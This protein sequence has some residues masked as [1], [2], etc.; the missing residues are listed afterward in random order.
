[1]GVAFHPQYAQNGSFYVNYT[2][3]DGDTVV[4][5]YQVSADPNV[6]DPG[7]GA[8]ILFH[9]DP[10][11]NHNGGNLV[12]GP[13]GYLWIG[14]GDGGAG[15]DPLGSGQNGTSLL[16]KML[17]IDVNGAF[18]YAIPPDNPF[19]GNPNVLPEIWA[20]GLRNP[21]RY[22]F[23]RQT[24]D[25]WIGDV[26]QNSWEEVNFIPAG[27]GG[28][29][30]FGWNVAEGNHCFRSASCDLTPFVAPVAEY[31]TGPDG[32]AVV[33]GYV[34]RGA[35]H[36]AMFG[37]YLYADECS[38][39]VWSLVRNAAGG[40]QNAE[41]ARSRANISSFGEDEAGE[42]YVAGYNDGTIYRVS[43]E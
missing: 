28:G 10:Y 18:P 1:L 40:W 29:H 39:R 17:R 3:L 7:T 33:S 16:G 8:V 19:V 5:Q 21:W 27:S 30:N 26:G 15:G 14:L 4:A 37:T 12:F 32:C 11:P 6:A 2:N 20:F 42:L 35:A 13:D 34:Y 43:G 25:L 38:A 24:G 31:R 23:D 9:E 22:T 36:P 41:L